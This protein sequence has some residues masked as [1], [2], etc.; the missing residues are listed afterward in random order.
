[1][2]PSQFFKMLSDETRLRCLLLIAREEGLCVRELT[3]AMNES[4]PKISRHLA[5]L[6]QS[7]VLV[8]ERKGQWVMYKVSDSLPGWL[9]KVVSGLKESN[10]LKQQYLQDIERLHAYSDRPAI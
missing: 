3:E 7:G 2:S 5:L 8:D 4:Q 6:R 9:L 10:C 1:M